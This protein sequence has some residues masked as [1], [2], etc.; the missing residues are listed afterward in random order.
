MII[1]YELTGSNM[2]HKGIFDTAGIW[3][4]YES[5]GEAGFPEIEGWKIYSN[6]SFAFYHTDRVIVEEVYNVLIGCFRGNQGREIANIGYIR[7]LN[8]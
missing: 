4:K 8:K 5:H 3:V 6:F 2:L 7:K 1:E